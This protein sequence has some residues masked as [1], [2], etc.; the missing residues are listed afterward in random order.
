M[1]WVFFRFVTMHAFDRRTDRRTDRIP[2]AIPRLHSM[3]RGKNCQ[4]L[5]FYWNL[6][7]EIANAHDGQIWTLKVSKQKFGEL[8][9]L[10]QECWIRWRH[11]ACAPGDIRAQWRHT[12]YDV[13]DYDGVC[14]TAG[15]HLEHLQSVD[16]DTWRAHIHI[17]TPCRKNVL[18]F[19]WLWLVRWW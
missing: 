8:E 19:H 15:S 13:A 4:I 6:R 17:I 7:A 11:W 14:M 9:I 5:S 3:Q 16:S 18:L 2:I 1:D 12:E 10:N